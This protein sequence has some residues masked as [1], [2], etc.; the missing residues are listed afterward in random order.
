VAVTRSEIPDPGHGHGPRQQK[1]PPGVYTQVNIMFPSEQV[2]L[3]PAEKFN[4]FT[5]EAQKSILAAFDREGIERHA[6]LK[7]QQSYD[8][9]LNSQSESHFFIWRMTGTI[10]GSVL[11]IVAL[12]TGAWLVKSGSSAVGVSTILF[13]IAGLVGSAIYGAKAVSGVKQSQS[14]DESSITEPDDSQPEI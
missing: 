4:A 5:P 3:P 6:W 7:N 1:V 10:L 11:A 14:T 8:F 2:E 9:R 12:L 13:A